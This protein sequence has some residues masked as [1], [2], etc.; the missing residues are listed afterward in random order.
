MFFFPFKDDNPTKNKPFI[1][2]FIIFLCCLI[3][4][5]QFSLS[6]E[7]GY[8][9]I[10]VFGATP[11]LLTNELFPHW[12][13]ILSSMFLHGSL[14]HLVGNLVYLWIFGDNIEDEF[15]KFNFIIFYVLCGIGAVIAQ[16]LLDPQSNVP[17]IG[18]S[19]AIAGLLGSYVVLHPKAK[20]YVFAWVI[21]FVKLIKVP[22]FIVISI[23]IALQ[24]MNVFD[25]G[26][27]G[28]A[29]SAHI[30]GFFT[31][32]IL[33]PIFKKNTTKI[34][35]QDTNKPYISRDISN[36]LDKDSIL[37][38]MPSNKK[39]EKSNKNPWDL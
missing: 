14:M 22:A 1:S 4:L 24:F 39:K 23:W 15:G 6:S 37:R 33:T 7:D 35:T 30:G 17:M 20:I 36:E 3:Y 2:Y 9:I 11:Y 25:Q 34:F 27:S 8:S 12:Y 28:V 38:H 10:K 26:S 32:L 31:G 16:I 19:G 5:F 13:S 18:A 29:Y 21:I